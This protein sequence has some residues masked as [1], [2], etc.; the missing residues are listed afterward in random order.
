MGQRGHCK[1][2]GLYFFLRKREKN[3]Q[4]GTGFF[5]RHGILSA[6]KSVKVVSD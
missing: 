6:V 4:L 3:H 1:S 2:R 5:V